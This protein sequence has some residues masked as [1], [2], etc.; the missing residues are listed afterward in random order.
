MGTSFLE[1]PV[2]N[3]SPFSKHITKKLKRQAKGRLSVGTFSF[4]EKAKFHTKV[5]TYTHTYIERER[6]ERETCIQN[7]RFQDTW[8]SI[9]AFTVKMKKCFRVSITSSGEVKE[10]EKE[11]ISENRIYETF[12]MNGCR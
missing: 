1:N 6:R 7:L 11:F 8:L 2:I 9:L 12:I 10:R 5:E 3:F 4:R